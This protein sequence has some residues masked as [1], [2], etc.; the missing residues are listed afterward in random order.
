MSKLVEIKVLVSSPND[1]EHQAAVALQAVNNLNTI[2]N[3]LGH[4]LK[5]MH[6]KSNTSTGRAERAQEV[7]NDQTEDCDAIIAIFGTRFGTPT[8]D[9]LSGTEEEVRRFIRKPGGT[10]PSYDVHVFFNASATLNPLEID[11][12]QLVR[13]QNF[14]RYL[15][16]HGV[17]YAQFSS[18]EQL[19]KLVSLAM[20]TLIAKY[21]PSVPE[22]SDPLEEFEEL[23]SLDA[24]EI[25][26]EALL[27]ATSHIEQIGLLMEESAED[28]NSI[29]ANGNKASSNQEARI[30]FSKYAEALDSIA[31]KV[32]PH[33][34]GMKSEVAKGYAYLAYALT[35]TI[36]DAA[37]AGIAKNLSDLRNSIEIAA[38]GVEALKTNSS[39]LKATVSDIPRLTKELTRAKRRALNV[40]TD[41]HDSLDASLQDFHSLIAVIDGA[42]NSHIENPQ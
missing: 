21:K 8:G 11:P 18:D 29:V 19:S 33:V 15:S 31:T 22:E 26:A 9:F 13:V 25:S 23:G 16:E 35:I 27:N 32:W 40:F 4:S 12:N 17:A 36:E 7:I 39:R 20:S 38:A 10:S 30:F 34:L 5:A 42:P 14:G 24:E 3:P 1:Q 2:L 41:L 28:V 37:A 6:W